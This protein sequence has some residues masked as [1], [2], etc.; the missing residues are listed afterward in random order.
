MKKIKGK[1]L[2][3]YTET[4]LEEERIADT[5]PLEVIK[6]EAVEIP[7]Q[8]EPPKQEIVVK[9]S[10]VVMTLYQAYRRSVFDPDPDK[11][12]A[13]YMKKR[14]GYEGKER[15]VPIKVI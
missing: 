4:F 12:Y 7:K 2:I 3:D 8:P 1:P 13:M 10:P 9:R 6:P 15:T 14:R 11:N 5:P